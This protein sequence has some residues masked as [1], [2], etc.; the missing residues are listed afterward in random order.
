MFRREDLDTYMKSSDGAVGS[1][2]IYGKQPSRCA[3]NDAE[4]FLQPH[5]RSLLAVAGSYDCRH[6]LRAIGVSGPLPL[7]ALA[8]RVSIDCVR[9]Q[10]TDPGCDDGH[11]AATETGDAQP[12]V[13]VLAFVATYWL[14][15]ILGLLQPGR[16][17]AANW[18]TTSIAALGLLI[19]VWARL[20]LGR[21]IGFV[22]AQREL[23]ATGA[24]CLHASSRV[25]RWPSYEPCF[26]AASL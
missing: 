21:N 15:L 20:S 16:P 17:V 24:P 3:C 10:P 7:R 5:S 25:Y 8:S 11:S 26:P 9:G 13:L 18:V 4:S 22:P 23:V 12:V 6:C 19:V 14:I 2:V 1:E